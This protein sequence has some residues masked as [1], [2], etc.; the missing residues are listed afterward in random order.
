MNRAALETEQA[1]SLLHL[2]KVGLDSS[3]GCI[4]TKSKKQ[5]G[6]D[7]TCLKGFWKNSLAASTPTPKAVIRTDPRVDVAVILNPGF[8]VRSIR[9]TGAI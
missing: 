5:C 2:T 6:T 7:A 4:G 1:A 9:S 3:S 8:R